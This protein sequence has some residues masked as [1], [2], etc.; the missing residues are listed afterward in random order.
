MCQ[1]TNFTFHFS[2]RG[3]ETLGTVPVKET[4]FLVLARGISSGDLHTGFS[5]LKILH[6]I[7]RPISPIGTIG[8][9]GNW[10]W[11][12]VL[13]ARP[14]TQCQ[15]KAKGRLAMGLLEKIWIPRK[16]TNR[17]QQVET[18]HFLFH[19]CCFPT[20]IQLGCIFVNAPFV[21]E[22]CQQWLPSMSGIGSK[23]TMDFPAGDR[24]HRSP[25]PSLRLEVW[26]HLGKLWW[27]PCRLIWY[28]HIQYMILYIIQYIIQY[29]Y[30]YITVQ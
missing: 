12:T 13:T 24:W 23:E 4:W 9:L 16:H 6:R 7:A 18:H 8:L 22:V 3:R 1:K 21:A 14:M 11:V 10:A 17:I 20:A 30:I 25:S 29:I 28:T 2:E 5:L 27:F 26:Q 19:M 15:A